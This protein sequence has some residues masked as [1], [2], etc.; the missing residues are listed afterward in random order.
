MERCNTSLGKIAVALADAIVES[1]AASRSRAGTAGSSAELAWVRCHD[2]PA[3]AC[4]A[5][6]PFMSSRLWGDALA[7]A[8]KCFWRGDPRLA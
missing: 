4:P 8:R 5:G 6:D 3:L 1:A 2:Q 7:S